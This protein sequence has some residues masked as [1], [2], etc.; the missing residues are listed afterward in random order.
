MVWKPNQNPPQ[1]T[2][3]LHMQ[4]NPPIYLPKPNQTKPN[5][6]EPNEKPNQPS[7]PTMV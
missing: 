2:M 1:P 7:A 5:Q 3:L 4:P 6:T